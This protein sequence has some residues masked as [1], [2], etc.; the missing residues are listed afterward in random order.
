MMTDHLLEDEA[1]M[2]AAVAP[3]VVA[4]VRRPRL[5]E[6]SI[7]SASVWTAAIACFVGAGLGTAV[8][9]AMLHVVG[10]L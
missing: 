10:R 9:V 5:L 7:A 8:V 4:L 6:V 3:P 1:R 2:R